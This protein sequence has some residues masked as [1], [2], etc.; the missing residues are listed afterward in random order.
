MASYYK[1][2]CNCEFKIIESD[3]PP[4]VVPLLE[5]DIENVPDDCPATFELLSSGRTKGIFQLES[6]LGRTWTK[7]L[8]PEN[9]EHLGALGALLRPGTLMAK[10]DD[11]ISMTEHYIR[12]KNGQEEIKSY[13]PAVD[14]VLDSTYRVL[15]Y[16]E[17]SMA[18]AKEI[19]GFSMEEA[20][21]LRKSIGKKLASEMAKCETMFAE[22]AKK[23]GI[24]N[25]QQ[26]AEV[27]G[28]IKQSQ[29]YS[30]NKCIPLDE[31]ILLPNGRQSRTVG[32]MFRVRNH[33]AY[34]REL[35]R[36]DQH[37]EWREAGNYGV[38]LSMF[39]DNRIYE[40]T[41]MDIR[42]A[43][44]KLVYRIA[45]ANGMTVRATEN[46]RFPTRTGELTVRQMLDS[47]KYGARINLFYCNNR[48]KVQY[49]HVVQIKAEERV[50]V[51]DV[52][53]AEPA[54]NFVTG[55]GIITNNSHA[56]AY[57]LTGYDTAYIK[58]HFPLAFYAA[59]LN[60]S[61]FKNSGGGPMEEIAEL[62]NDAR[63]FNVT[64]EPPD[65]R[66]LNKSFKTDRRTIT[67][68][69]ADVKGIGDAQVTKLQETIRDI[70]QNVIKKK[71]SDWNWLEFL[72]WCSDKISGSAL[73]KLIQ[74]GAMRWLDQNRTKM[75]AEF[76]AWSSLSDKEKEW[77]QL[78]SSLQAL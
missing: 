5:F 37:H 71:L 36:E 28:W 44:E 63:Y 18:L 62:V 23:T 39:S 50:Q 33:L 69:L 45:L 14:A 66:N 1:F 52:E 9:L 73:T 56:V 26:A 15:V 74:V 4:D 43:G 32:E 30:F 19:A 42:D 2:P 60:N 20:D 57:G 68:G 75:L 46:H 25:E 27:F 35:G 16:Q 77:A 47:I 29:R 11:G 48:Y 6:P 58:A 51:Y 76:N 34:A 72:V 21:S 8:K 61:R 67:F 54:H 49:D 70:E 78:H 17:S 24:L 53:M 40:N 41:I 64:I 31:T 22:G 13:H 65:L 10:D 12:R 3:P 38:G 59:W 55:Q 7:K